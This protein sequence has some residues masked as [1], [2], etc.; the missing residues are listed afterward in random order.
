MKSNPKENFFQYLEQQRAEK[1]ADMGGYLR[2]LRQEQSLSLEEVAAKTKVQAR[3]LQALEE[4]RLDILPEPIYIKGFIKRYADA[5]GLN[6][7]E[8]SSVFPTAQGWHHKKPSLIG[9]PTFQLKTV[10]LYLLY[11]FLVICAVLGL[12]NLVN[13]SAL[14]LSNAA[15][16]KT[17][18]VRPPAPVKPPS[19]VQSPAPVPSPAQIQTPS[20]AQLPPQENTVQPEKTALASTAEANNPTNPEDPVRVSVTLKAESWIR[21]VADGKKEFEGTLPE[22]E[23]RTWIAKQELIV[24]AGNAGGVIVAVNEGEAKQLGDPGAPKTVTFKASTE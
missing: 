3:L 22:G 21:V 5:L 14:Q 15:P 4:A 9:L 7:A 19:Q 20:Q 24:R 6:G 10:H 12:S 23:Q 2:H 18:P 11:V 1:L 13:R 17:S 8:F 16:E